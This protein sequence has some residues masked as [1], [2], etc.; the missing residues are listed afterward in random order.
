MDTLASLV[1]KVFQLH[2]TFEQ[3]IFHFE[4]TLTVD[5]VYLDPF[6]YIRDSVLNSCR[7]AFDIR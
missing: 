7:N 5:D 6:S 1:D 4:G 2:K 3:P